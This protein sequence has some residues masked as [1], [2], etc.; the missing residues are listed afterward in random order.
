MSRGART[1]EDPPRLV[2]EAAQRN[3]ERTAARLPH[4]VS[5]IPLLVMSIRDSKGIF[6]VASSAGI[7]DAMAKHLDNCLVVGVVEPQT[8]HI[9]RQATKQQNCP[10]AHG[11]AGRRGIQSK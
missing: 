11:L 8:F 5:V 2:I 3:S 7:Q 1:N 9:Q 6:D 4:K 10:S